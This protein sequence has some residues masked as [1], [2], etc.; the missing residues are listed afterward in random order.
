MSTHQNVFIQAQ[1]APQS[2]FGW[3]F[4]PDN[5]RGAHD[6]GRGTK[7]H[8]SNTHFPRRL[9]LLDLGAVGL[10]QYNIL[11]DYATDHWQIVSI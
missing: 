6:A 3:R 11:S 10:L 2:V 4:A 1:S 9:R 8:P 7:G 5:A